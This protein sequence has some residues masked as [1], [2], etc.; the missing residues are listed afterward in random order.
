MCKSAPEWDG[1]VYLAR[2]Q[3]TVTAHFI[4]QIKPDYRNR[5]HDAKRLMTNTTYFQ[6]NYNMMNTN[7]GNHNMNNTI[8]TVP[9]VTAPLLPESNH[10]YCP[11][12]LYEHV[13]Y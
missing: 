7:S 2:I 11:V 8:R 9:Y 12:S 3:Y 5:A 6:C 13:I 1:L 4:S 10:R